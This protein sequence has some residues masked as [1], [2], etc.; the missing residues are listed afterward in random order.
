MARW[1]G[2]RFDLIR[3]LESRTIGQA[4]VRVRVMAGHPQEAKSAQMQDEANGGR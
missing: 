2:T 3:M 4:A 1:L